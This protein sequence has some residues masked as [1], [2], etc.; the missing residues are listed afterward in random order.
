MPGN[1][2]YYTKGGPFLKHLTLVNEN[3]KDEQKHSFFCLRDEGN[4]VQFLGVDTGKNEHS[5]KTHFDKFF[6]GCHL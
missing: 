4:N 5:I 6:T 1:H 3:P 2:D